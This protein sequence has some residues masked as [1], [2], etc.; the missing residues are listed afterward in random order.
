MRGEREGGEDG[1]WLVSERR[2]E[3]KREGGRGAWQS[4]EH[5]QQKT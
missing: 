5:V 2:G 1:G 4:R 3:G